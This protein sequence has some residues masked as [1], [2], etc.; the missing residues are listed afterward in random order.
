MVPRIPFTKNRPVADVSPSVQHQHQP[1]PPYEESTTHSVVYSEKTTTTTT[2]VVTTTTTQT[3]THLISSPLWRKHVTPVA[4]DHSVASERSCD[5]FPQRGPLRVEKDLPPTPTDEDDIPSG[6]SSRRDSAEEIMAESMLPSLFPSPDGRACPDALPV[7]QSSTAA[8]A[9]ASLGVG[10]PHVLSRSSPS[11]PFSEVNTVAFATSPIPTS[12]PG[13]RQSKSSQKLRAVSDTRDGSNGERRRTRGLSLNASTFLSFSVSDSKGKGKAKEVDEDPPPKTLSRRASFW[14]RKK[15]PVSGLPTPPKDSPQSTNLY[16]PLPSVQP[17]SPFFMN[18]DPRSTASDRQSA[19]TSHTRGLS[20][21]HSE[22]LSNGRPALP[23]QSLS[24]SSLVPPKARRPT[25]RPATADPLNTSH[26]AGSLFTDSPRFTSSPLSNTPPSPPLP[27]RHDLEPPESQY[28]NRRPRAQTNPPLL[29]RLSLSLLFSSSVQPS[30]PFTLVSNRLASASSSSSSP[31]ISNNNSPRPSL[32]KTVDIPKP[33]V[34]DESPEIYLDRL[35]AVVSKAEVAG[36]LAASA[37]IFHVQALRAYISRFNF[38]NDPLDVA[39]RRLL[40]DVGLPRETQQIDRVMEA[41]AH[42]YVSCHPNLFTSEDHPYILAFSLIMLHTDAF[43]KSNKRKMTKADYVKNTRLPGVSSEVLDCFY[44]N[45]VFAPFIFVEDPLD[46]NG[47]RGFVSE[48]SR[49]N[50]SVSGT[51]PNGSGSG[52]LGK[53]NKVDPYYLISNNLLG[54]LRVDVERYIPAS[55]PYSWEGT[56]GRW[57]DD[58]LQ[59][60]FAN[61]T[62]VE[63]VL[64]NRLTSPFFGMGSPPSPL[65]GSLGGLPD[66]P[67]LTGEMY[68]LRVSKAGVLSRKDDMLEGGKKSTHRKWRPM[69]VVLTGSQLLFFRDLTWANTLAC[70]SDPSGS[71]VIY[72]QATVFNPDESISVKDC[73]AVWDES[74]TKHPNVFR[75]V[76]H[77]G[78]QFLLQASDDKDLNEWISRINYASSFKSAGVRI[79]PMGMSRRDVKLTGVAAATSHLHDLQH[80]NQATPVVRKWGG[81]GSHESSSPLSGEQYLPMMR[82]MQQKVTLMNDHD[83]VEQDVPMAPEVE[84]ADQF[85][86]TFDQVKADLSAG[87]WSYNL[88]RADELDLQQTSITSSDSARSDISGLPSRSNVILSKIRDLDARI[89]ASQSQLDSDLRF[90]RN[91]ATL[92][93]F[94]RHTRYRLLLAIQGVSKRIMQERLEFTKLACHRAVLSRDF[95][96]EGREWNRIK[97]IALKAAAEMLQSQQ[98]REAPIPTMTVSFHD[99]ENQTTPP[100]SIWPSSDD[101]ASSNFLSSSQ[102]YESPKASPSELLSYPFPDVNTSTYSV[103][104]ND[105]PS[106]RISDEIHTHEKYYTAVEE[107]EE[108]DKTKCAQRVSLV[109]LPSTIVLRYER[110]VTHRD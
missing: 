103:S 102:V 92:T 51:S 11:S 21:S 96:A 107:A 15:I 101:I 24:T 8:L 62:A 40:M 35:C 97:Q 33:R 82:P 65:I 91:I 100:E 86:A 36:V 1:P 44:D 104:R 90:V 30:S 6:S 50:L 94:Q 56:N 110:G 29:H 54:A 12:R 72:P 19:S 64:D 77:D 16:T 47:Q 73:I 28:Q 80:M 68:T 95:A 66:S 70:S 59:S 79:R 37:D 4:T 26:A 52:I 53:G 99:S 31:A 38:A 20:R 78:R 42:Q 5:M 105:G 83:A 9:H 84:G 49:I 74:Y 27:Q 22:C 93:P 89:S 57:D 41:F 58:E 39:L 75:F 61:A 43:N 2:E 17:G 55:H 32:H 14:T 108:W 60:V 88:V 67:S 3:T 85:K 48:G 23:E 87:R 81:G 76:M 69:S 18:L 98:P 7:L 34:D 109:R 63:I 13:L 25:R 45:I 46:I 106:P 10:L 71:Q